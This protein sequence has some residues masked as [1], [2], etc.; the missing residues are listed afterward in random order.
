VFDKPTWE[1][2][3]LCVLPNAD[4]KRVFNKDQVDWMFSH[5]YTYGSDLVQQGLVTRF[6]GVDWDKVQAGPTI[7]IVQFNHQTR[8]SQI[9]HH[10]EIPKGDF[11]LTTAVQR[12]LDLD[13]EYQVQRLLVDRGYGDFQVEYLKQHCLDSGPRGYERGEKVEGIAFQSNFH[14][15]DPIT[16]EEGKKQFKQLMVNILQFTMQ[17]HL[18]IGSRY[19]RQLAGQFGNFAYKSRTLGNVTFVSDNEHGVDSVGLAVFGIYRAFLEGMRAEIATRTIR[20]E[21]PKVIES[22][23]TQQERL[24]RYS[25]MSPWREER[26]AGGFSRGFIQGTK[27]SRF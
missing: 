6:M 13:K 21:A 15:Y 10:E 11:A 26:G 2:E 3:Y 14:M 20:V 18:L 23:Q 17:E 25:Q 1:R 19:D 7:S 24:A 22:A 16:G 5:D 9:I 8:L 12:V 27:R 4:D